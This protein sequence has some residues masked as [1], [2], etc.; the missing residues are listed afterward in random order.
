MK[1][2]ERN[3]ERDEAIKQLR[4]WIPRSST[5]Y[6]ILRHRSA[7]GM[8]RVIGLVVFKD[9]QDIHP[10]YSASKALGWALDKNREGIRVSGCG[11]DMGHH[12]VYSLSQLLYGWNEDGSYNAEGAYSL[13]QRWL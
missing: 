1:Q 5:I 10:N 11:M 7:S 3:T 4:E 9:G 2:S 13:K 12:L 6:T 8:T